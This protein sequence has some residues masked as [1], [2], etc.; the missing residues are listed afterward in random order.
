[1]NNVNP[2]AL[3]GTKITRNVY[4]YGCLE[5]EIVGIFDKF[6]DIDNSY[7]RAININNGS[8]IFANSKFTERYIEDEG[9]ASSAFKRYVLYFDTYK[10]MKNFYSSN[11]DEIIHFPSVPKTRAVFETMFSIMLPLSIFIALFTVLFYI[12]LTFY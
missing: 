8:G 1:M 7:F 3:I 6:T 5:F 11:E 10:D 12:N 9:S 4:K 2:E